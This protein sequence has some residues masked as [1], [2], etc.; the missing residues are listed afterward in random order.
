MRTNAAANKAQGTFKFTNAFGTGPT[1]QVL[2][3]DRDV[4]AFG[5]G[6]T[7]NGNSIFIDDDNIA[8]GDQEGSGSVTINSSPQSQSNIA[9]VS[10]SSSSEFASGFLPS[11]VSTCTCQYLNWGFW[12]GR[13]SNSG[14]SSEMIHM[15]NYIVGEIAGLAAISALQGTATY[16]GHAIG[17]VFTNNQVY[18]AIGGLSATV[19]FDNTSASTFSISNFDGANYTGTGLA[20]TADST[21]HKFTGALSGA[22]RSGGY[23]GS[24]MKGGGDV[25][26]EMGGQFK[27]DGGGYSAVGIFAA[28]K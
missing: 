12:G 18:Q 2:F 22:G 14:S 26:A 3:G 27:V 19:N 17:T 4:G 20:I 6:S 16:N 13:I 23:T 24:F 25:A 11:G 28:A 5:D 21:Q 15:A 8:G 7:T 1:F 10:V 9:F